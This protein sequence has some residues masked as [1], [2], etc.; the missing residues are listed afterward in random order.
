MTLTITF[1]S[2]DPPQIHKTGEYTSSNDCCFKVK[3][4]SV[5]SVFLTKRALKNI[6]LN[7]VLAF[8]A[9]SR[10]ENPSVLS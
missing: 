10:F 8:D 6:D 4:F 3:Y 2:R 9:L 5:N 7:F 1:S